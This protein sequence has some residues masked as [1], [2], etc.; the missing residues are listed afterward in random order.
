[1]SEECLETLCVLL[2]V[3]GFYKSNILPKYK[4][5]FKNCSSVASKNHGISII[6]SLCGL[7]SLSGT[8]GWHFPG[9]DG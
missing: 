8:M 7:H 6:L 1:M 9:P 4:V 3:V 2:A 5:I